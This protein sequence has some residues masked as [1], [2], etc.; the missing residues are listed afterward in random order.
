MRVGIVGAGMA[1]LT[2]AWLIDGTH[3][4]VVF[5]RG[6]RIGGNARSVAV[7]LGGRPV[8]FDLGT[9]EM[10]T[11][12]YP[13]NTRLMRLHG[14][15][16]EDFVEVPASRTVLRE[17]EE[18]PLLV[19]P[20]EPD[21]GWPRTKVLGRHWDRLAEFLTRAQEWD[22]TGLDWE[23]RLDEM[24]DSLGTDRRNR[25]LLYALPAALFGCEPREAG[26]LSARAATAAFLGGQ[27]SD[28]APVT[29][30]V[31]GGLESLAWSLA[32]DLHVARIRPDTGVVRVR[33]SGSGYE[34]VDTTGE[35]TRVEAV[36]FAVPPPVTAE[37]A[38]SLDGLRDLGATLTAF[39]YRRVDYAL[40]RDPVG[41]PDRLEHWSTN[42]LTLGENHSETTVWYGP[43]HGVDVFRSQV[44]RRSRQPSKVLAR[45]SF[46]QLLP[47]P[48]VVRAQRRLAAH[49]GTDNLYFAGHYAFGIDSQETTVESAALVAR[50]LAPSSPR[51]ARLLGTE[52][53]SHDD[54]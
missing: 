6:R 26:T 31:R 18:S 23:V 3:E 49:Q 42:N 29:E 51:V 53:G 27:R 45:E 14:F 13:L 47:T 34:L 41:M 8:W 39:P 2:V 24:L 20:H 15:G 40:H 46:R 12:D 30:N 28:H 7:R 10:S 52:E 32:T 50:R 11:E 43:V 19:G 44:S 5:E 35:V 25:P 1:G 22:N 36:V 4:A 16:D 38:G 21:P 17:G 37:L 9:Q 33:Q 54:R 48:E